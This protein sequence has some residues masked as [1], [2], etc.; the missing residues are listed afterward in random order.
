[1]KRF[2]AV[3]ALVVPMLVII[4]G[5]G[6]G[7]KGFSPVTPPVT[8][9]TDS[10]KYLTGTVLSSATN[11][12]VRG[13]I[14]RLGDT[15]VTATTDSNGEFKI[16]ISSI[17]ELP[18]H[19]Q[20]DTSAAGPNFPK[21][22]LVYYKDQ[23]FYPDWIDMPIEVLN[24]DT[25]EL[26]IIKVTEVTDP[27]NP[28]PVPYPSKNTVIV[29]RVVKASDNKG[30]PNVEVRFGTVTVYPARTGAKGYFAI[31]LGRDA[32]VL[33]I[34]SG[35]PWPPTFSIDVTSAGLSS[36]LKVEFR[37]SKVDQNSIPVP[38][39]VL[40]GQT[41]VLGA[42]TILDTG[43]NGTTPPPPPPPPPF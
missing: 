11:K 3:F 29:G 21:T 7:G 23:T 25:K 31:N 6:G 15:A 13:V 24:G 14:I 35:G 36:D 16:D 19:F 5:C 34:F 32:A 10:G 26:G 40:T 12:G 41:T 27:N 30:V 20:V 17:S 42:I 18:Y 37:G 43:G 1:M 28:P 38:D 4:S 9:P 8:P 39:E 2:V 22:T 33:P